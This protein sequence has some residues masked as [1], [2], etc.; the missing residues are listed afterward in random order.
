MASNIVRRQRSRTFYEKA[1]DIQN[2]IDGK[3]EKVKNEFNSYNPA[4]NR[5][6][7]YIPNSTEEDVNRAVIAAK[8]AF[9]RYLF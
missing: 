6:N 1:I 7:A 8:K 3:F 4:L 9:E 5:V 2:Y